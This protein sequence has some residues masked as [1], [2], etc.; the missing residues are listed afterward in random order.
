VTQPFQ[1]IL[2]ATDFS[3]C[4]T[5]ALRYALQLASPLGAAVDVV[6][7]WDYRAVYSRAMAGSGPPEREVER[8]QE[9]AS[10]R[11]KTFCEGHDIRRRLVRGGEAAAEVAQAAA[12]Y[13]M[14]VVGTHGRQGVSRLF[15]GSVAEQIVRTA[16]CPVLTVRAPDEE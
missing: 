5:A 13:D 3:T 1:Q 11:L 8:M 9:A 14:L 7:A 6:H 4:S 12:G 16:P 15:L 2:V 10:A